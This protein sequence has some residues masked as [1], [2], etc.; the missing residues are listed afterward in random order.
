[1]SRKRDASARRRPGPRRDAG[2]TE[3]AGAATWRSVRF[4]LTVLGLL[5]LFFLVTRLPAV[6]RHVV[7]PYTGFVAWS[8]ALLLRAAGAGVSSHGN[9]VASPAFS[10]A[11]LPVC[12]GLEVTAIY[13]AAV[14]AFPA[15][16]SGKAIGLAGGL[17]IIYLINIVR[18]AALFLIGAHYHV[19]FEQ[20][21]YYYAQ[22]FVIVATTGVW[23]AWVSL[24]SP[25]GLKNR[26][27]VSD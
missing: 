2:G 4:A 8:S 20:A 12:N 16:L 18:I 17:V 13:A 1:M 23:L 9:V 15:A 27:P 7:T 19:A 14:L 6:D 3:P 21:H 11:I 24:F 22:A 25:Y 10:V 26:R 5:V